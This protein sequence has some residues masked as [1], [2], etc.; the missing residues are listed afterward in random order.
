M[1]R[2]AQWEVSFIFP[3][4]VP[5]FKSLKRPGR[6]FCIGLFTSNVLNT[7][8]HIKHENTNMCVCVKSVTSFYNIFHYST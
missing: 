8:N 7:A 4:P 3:L 2:K 6:N 5:H 1:K